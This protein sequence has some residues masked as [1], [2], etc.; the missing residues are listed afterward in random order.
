MLPT[1]KKQ[2]KNKLAQFR[3]QR[4]LEQKHVA[5]LLGH[6]KTTRIQRLESGLGVPDLKTA[7]KL[8][9][10]YNVPV[11]V[12]LDEYYK[13]CLE[14]VRQQEMA[15]SDGKTPDSTTSSPET[16]EFCTYEEKLK[17]PLLSREAFVK[18][19]HHSV[20]LVRKTAEKLGDL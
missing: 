7:L 16:P 15:L 18:V 17:A 19:R 1:Q 14:E 10:I 9:R 2:F 8:A 6:K 11:R 5:V 3:L 20:D 4:R 12:M 13:A